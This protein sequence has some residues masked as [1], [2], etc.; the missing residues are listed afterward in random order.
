MCIKVVFPSDT[1]SY[2][3]A[4]LSHYSDSSFPRS[5][6]QTIPSTYLNTMVTN[7]DDKFTC[8]IL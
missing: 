8:Q 4:I 7:T 2:D 1:S 6:L 3:R 5:D